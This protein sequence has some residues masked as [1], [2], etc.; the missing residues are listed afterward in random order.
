MQGANMMQGGFVLF[1]TWM[2]YLC[3]ARL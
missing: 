2:V 3:Y 1:S